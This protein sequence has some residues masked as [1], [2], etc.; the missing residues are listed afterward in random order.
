MA[1]AFHARGELRLIWLDI[2]GEPAAFNYC[3]QRGPRLYCLKI[4]IDDRFRPLA[5]G[6]LVDYCTVRQCFE[7]GLERYEL[8]GAD[9]PYKR[10]FATGYADHV[11]LR[12]YRRRPA[13]VM[14]Y[15]VRRLGRPV[16]M[17]ARDR[18]TH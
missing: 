1:R 18:L 2:D 5:P 8:L 11:R 13:P 15:L 10:Y 7:L 6:L 16:V 14:R 12:T 17:A 9:E 4:G 3:L